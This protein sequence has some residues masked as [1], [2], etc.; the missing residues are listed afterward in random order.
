MYVL[1]NETGNAIFNGLTPTMRPRWT[2]LDELKKEEW[3]F[4]ICIYKNA[5]RE[6]QS[7]SNMEIKVKAKPLA[8]LIS[9]LEK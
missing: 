4:Q 5:E 3:G 9:F 2:Q 7:L 1:L 6:I 8:E